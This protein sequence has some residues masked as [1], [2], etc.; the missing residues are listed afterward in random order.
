MALTKTQLTAAI[1]A[2]DLALP[3]ASTATGFPGIGVISYP[4]QPVLIDQEMMFLIMVPA[5]N[6]LLVRCRGADGTLAVPHDITAPVITSAAPGDFLVPAPG[7]LTTTPL[8][9]PREFTYGQSGPITP[10]AQPNGAM[11]ILNGPSALAMTLAAPSLAVTGVTLTI[12]TQ[13][14]FAHTVIAP[15]LIVTGAA[16][17]PFSTITFPAAVGAQ[18]D[19][20][21]Q[22]GLW[23]VG[24]INGIVGYS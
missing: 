16:G 7:F 20:V 2:S 18:V 22:N 4:Q 21:A 14:A 1:K 12:L 6:T 11:A 3:V 13:T 17:G 10:P 8:D 23:S 9:S 19:L 24:G 5:V 15:G